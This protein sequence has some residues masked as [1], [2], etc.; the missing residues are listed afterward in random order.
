MATALPADQPTL[1]LF[2]AHALSPRLALCACVCVCVCVHVC[3]SVSL[4]LPEARGCAKEFARRRHSGW[5]VV[6]GGAGAGAGARE[7][8]CL[9]LQF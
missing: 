6:G 9:P 1:S 2:L 7:G 8:V 5:L 3:L 4:C